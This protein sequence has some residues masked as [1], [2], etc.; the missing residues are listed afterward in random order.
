MELEFPE[1]LI[2]K[3]SSLIHTQK[4]LK[5]IENVKNG[6]H[7]DVFVPADRGDSTRKSERKR[8]LSTQDEKI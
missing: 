7:K 4:Y 5:N 1:S 8:Q 2:V 3:R 6:I